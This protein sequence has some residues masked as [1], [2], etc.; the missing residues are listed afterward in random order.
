MPRRIKLDMPE[1]ITVEID[2]RDWKIPGDIDLAEI[3]PVFAAVRQV[4]DLDEENEEDLDKAADAFETVERFIKNLFLA[5]QEEE[6]VKRLRLG[7]QQMIK[8]LNLA[9]FPEGEEEDED[10]T[11]R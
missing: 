1:P 7:F 8:L 11:G 10:F 9:Y 2:G 5:Y 3:R 4:R 6:E